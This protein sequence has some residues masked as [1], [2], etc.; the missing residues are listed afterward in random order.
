MIKKYF[1]TSFRHLGHNKLYAFINVSG[2]AIAITCLL[3]AVLYV[4]DE[5]SY[6]RFHTKDIYRVLTNVTDAKGERKTVA[7]TGQ[8]QGPAFKE[9]VPEINEFVRVLGGDIKQDVFA[10]DKI[11]NLQV[12]FV[13]PGFFSMFS[14]PLLRGEPSL[15]LTDISSVVI[16]ETVARKLFNTTDVVGRFLGMDGDPSLKRVGKPMVISGVAKDPPKNSSIRFEIVQ[17]LR[18]M[19][20]SFTDENWLNQYLGTFFTFQEDARPGSVIKKFNQVYTAHAHKQVAENKRAYN[21]DPKISFGLQPVRDIHLHPMP[22]G[23]GWREGGIVNESNPV[24]SYLFLGIAIFILLMA[25]INFINISI[26]GSLNRAKE[27]GIRKIIGGSRQQIILQFLVESAIVCVAAFV[28]SLFLTHTL[29]PVFNSLTGK[30]L[31]FREAVDTRLTSWFVTIL[32]L[33]I[34]LTG[35]YPAWVLSAFKAREV[36]YNRQ[37]LSGRNLFGR[38][39]V[40]VQFSL[41][42]FFMISTL[43]YYR[44]MNFVHT[45]DLGYNPFQVLR[46]NIGGDRELKP[47]R[48]FLRNELAKEPAIKYVSFGGEHG[49]EEVQVANQVVEA[50]HQVIDENRLP[51]MEIKLKAGRNFSPAFPTDKKNAVLVNEAFV[52]AAGL[53]TP[54]GTTIRTSEYFDKEPK[55]IVGVIEDYHSGSLHKPVKPMVMIACDWYS[56]GIWIRIEKDKH[57]QAIKAIE[58]AYRKAVPSSLFSYSFLDELN[59]KAY[60]QEQR[61]QK[62]ISIAAVISILICCLGLF[63]LAHLAAQQRIKEIGVRKVLGASV[64][65]IA[66][67]LSKDFLLLVFIAFMIA[68]PIAWYTMHQWLQ[69]FAYKAGISGWVFLLAGVMAMGI[70][71]LTV[72]LHAVKAALANPVESLRTD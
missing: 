59:E 23:T 70:A 11:L 49:M 20:L 66:A 17:P 52:K 41:A 34:G 8:P 29:L 50:E 68:S 28:L 64:R 31:E 62:V 58:T 72:S 13:D 55:T 5:H 19:Q 38:A 15:V 26:A 51:V 61:W 54:L 57:Q 67:L 33:I 39:L 25:G 24:F 53:K 4:K 18:F 45:A 56:A 16:T 40:V 12:L 30:Q 2:L 47:I 32:L 65:S 27:V 43:I 7:G 44:Q 6:D 46:T 69:D 14:F 1:I 21:Y 60:L 10:N 9:A 36:L 35:V 71:L 63:G 22:T 42:V 37:K 3:L 48:D